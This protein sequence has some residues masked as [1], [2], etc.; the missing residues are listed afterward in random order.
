MILSE[1]RLIE[2]ILKREEEIS[3]HD[4]ILA[5]WFIEREIRIRITSP[6]T[7]KEYLNQEQEDTNGI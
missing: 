7:G 6:I 2:R 4:Y 3:E 1:L 5:L